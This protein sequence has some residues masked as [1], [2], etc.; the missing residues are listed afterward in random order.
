MSIEFNIP[1]NNLTTNINFDPLNN[2]K[3]KFFES[4]DNIKVLKKLKKEQ[5]KK[6]IIGILIGKFQMFVK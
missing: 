1:L 5:N 6:R 2:G 4:V 3:E